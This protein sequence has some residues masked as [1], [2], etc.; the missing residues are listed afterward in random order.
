MQAELASL[1]TTIDP[2]KTGLSLSA[3][4]AAPAGIQPA[5][6]SVLTAAAAGLSHFPPR[7]SPSP[8]LFRPRRSLRPPPLAAQTVRH[9]LIH[10]QVK[11]L[12]TGFRLESSAGAAWSS[13]CIRMWNFRSNLSLGCVQIF[14]LPRLDRGR[15]PDRMRCILIRSIGARSELPISC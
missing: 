10:F 3:G 9:K 2:I 8:R 1:D 5:R 15:T 4:I 7:L 11:T 12:N 6:S 13:D 14:K